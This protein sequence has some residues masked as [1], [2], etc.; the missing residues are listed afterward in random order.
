MEGTRQMTGWMFVAGE[1]GPEIDNRAA[2]LPVKSTHREIVRPRENVWADREFPATTNTGNFE[3]VSASFTDSGKICCLNGI[4]GI[5]ILYGCREFT[6]E[7]HLAI[8]SA[9]DCKRLR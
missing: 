6:F 7:N 4:T 5:G 8:G 3:V 9:P 2:A 1:S